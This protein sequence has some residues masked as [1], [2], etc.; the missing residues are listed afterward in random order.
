MKR[1]LTALLFGP[2]VPASAAGP[3]VPGVCDGAAMK[4]FVDLGYVW[5]TPWLPHLARDV[6]RL[7]AGPGRAFTDGW[8][9]FTRAMPMP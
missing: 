8:G 2:A 1:V 9:I 7:R 3:A 6:T 4:R 5:P